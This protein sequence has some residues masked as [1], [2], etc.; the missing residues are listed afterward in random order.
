MFETLTYFAI[1]IANIYVTCNK[2]L[3]KNSCV[4][5]KS[6]IIIIVLL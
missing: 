3:K 1:N 5:I 6:E 4:L 2:T